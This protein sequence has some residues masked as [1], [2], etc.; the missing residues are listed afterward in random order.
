MLQIFLKFGI[1]LSPVFYVAENLACWLHRPNRAL[2]DCELVAL[3]HSALSLSGWP[4]PQGRTQAR[5]SRQPQDDVRRNPF[6]F[7]DFFD[8]WNILTTVCFRAGQQT[9]PSRD[10]TSS[11]TRRQTPTSTGTSWSCWPR[12][13]LMSSLASWPGASTTLGTR[14]V[15]N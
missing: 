6:I 2:T 3:Q 7:V 9:P 10:W 4:L 5:D 15:I 13:A 8:A 14:Q 12:A 1:Y 11:S